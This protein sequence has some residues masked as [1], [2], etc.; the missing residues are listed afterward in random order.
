MEYEVA[1]EEMT[2]CGGAKHA[3]RSFIEVETDDPVQ[4]VRENGRFPIL[5]V[6]RNADGDTVITTG[7][8]KGY[9]IRYVFTA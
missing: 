1:V 2:P 9:R 5:D 8:E 4:Y 6:G 7:D 3:I